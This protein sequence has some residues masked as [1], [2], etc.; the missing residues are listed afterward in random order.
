MKKVLS[1][2]LILSVTTLSLFVSCSSNKEDPGDPP[3]V[4]D[5]STMVMD[6]SDFVDEDNG[7]NRTSNGAN[8]GVAALKVSVWN[9]LIGVTFAVPVASFRVTSSTTPEYDDDQGV[10]MWTAEHDYIGR[11]YSAT[12]TGKQEG[13]VIQWE[14]YVSQENGY[15]DFLW[16]TGTSQAD[17]SG[18]SWTLYQGPN[19]P[20]AL[21]EIE[22]ERTDEEIGQIRYSNVSGGAADGSYI[23]YGRLD[24]DDLDTYYTIN[25][26][27]TGNMV[28][29]QW[30]QDT[31]SGQIKDPGFFGDEDFHCWDENFEDAD[32]Q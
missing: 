13:E 15:Q 1:I 25:N 8:W 10:W 14:M 24:T 4:P 19:S 31:N 2:L 17:R 23:E 27:E 20:N 7:S 11:T 5:V 30:D 21:L 12:L 9:L 6:F 3:N 22:W 16:Y 26:V 28:E 29:I 32:C 18:G